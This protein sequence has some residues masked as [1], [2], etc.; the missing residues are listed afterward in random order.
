MEVGQKVA[1]RRF[2]PLSLHYARARAAS[3][4]LQC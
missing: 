3:L 4:M 2:A 1:R